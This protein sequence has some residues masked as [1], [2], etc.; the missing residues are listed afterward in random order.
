MIELARNSA[1]NPDVKEL[2][3]QNPSNKGLRTE[4]IALG[5]AVTAS[6]MIA[7]VRGCGQGWMSQ[8]DC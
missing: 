6:V 1:Q 3:Y 8:G 7:Q 2:G 5:A 4:R